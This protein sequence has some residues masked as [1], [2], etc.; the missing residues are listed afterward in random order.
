MDPNSQQIQQNEQKHLNQEKLA[1]GEITIAEAVGISP[2]EQ[3]EIAERGYQLFS[4]GKLDEAKVIYAGLVAASPYDSVF[5]CHLGAVLYRLGDV[6]QAFLEYDA[7]I[8]YNLANVD[9]LAGRGEIHFER[10]E[11]EQGIKDL[12]RAVELDE[13]GVHPASIR[14]RALLLSLREEAMKKDND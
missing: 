6:D 11:I 9:A 7:A 3:Y 12:Q 4:S 2:K 8:R 1:L 5:H 13:E 10:G 14:A